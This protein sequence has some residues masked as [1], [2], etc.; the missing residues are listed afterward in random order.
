MGTFLHG[1]LRV[2]VH[3]A[4]DLL[5]CDTTFGFNLVSK[6]YSDPDCKISMICPDEHDL[7]L[8]KTTRKD[9]DLNPEWNETFTFYVC[10]SVDKLKFTLRDKDHTS[11][12]DYLG[13]IFIEGDAIAKTDENCEEHEPIEEQWFDLETQGALCVTVRFTPN[14]PEKNREVESYFPVMEGN[15]VTLYQDAETP[16]LPC[17]EGVTNADD[18]QYE[19]TNCW[20]DLF[21]AIQEAE[22]FIYITGWSVCVNTSLLRDDD[23]AIAESN[24]GELLKAKAEAGVSVIVIVWDE[25]TSN[26][27]IP[28]GFMGT[29]DEETNN[30][31][32]DTKVQCFKHPRHQGG[33]AMG[34]KGMIRQDFSQTCYSHHQ[35][36]VILDAPGGADDMR[37]IIA[38][39]GGLDITDGRYD[40]PEF[41]LWS[42]ISTRHAN[43][44]D[45]Y[46]NCTPG[47]TAESGPRQPWH[48]IHAKIEGPAAA[49]V[50]QNFVERI[51]QQSESEATSILS[52]VEFDSE[53]EASPAESDGA[54]WNVQLFR[55]ITSESAIFDLDSSSGLHMNK[56]LYCENSIFRAYVQNIRN[57]QN[58]VYVE[59]QYFLGSSFDWTDSKDAAANHTVP[60]EIAFK[61]RNKIAAGEPFAAYIVIPMFPEGD[62][63][64]A[65]LQ[66]ILYWQHRTMQMMYTIVADAIKE[67]GVEAKP[68]DYLMFFCLAKREGMN[69]IP[70]DIGPP[71]AGTKA[72]LVRMTLRHPIYVHCKMLIVDDDYIIV[73]SANINQ[74]SLGGNRDSEIAFG[75]WQPGYTTEEMDGE[76]RGAV[77]TFRTALWAAH[78]GG[79]YDEIRSPQT[80]ECIEKV[81]EISSEYWERYKDDD[82][83]HEDVKLLRYP[84]NIDDDGV[85]SALDE[86]F[87]CFPDTTAPILGAK[88][89]CMPPKLTT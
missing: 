84:V 83:E 70:E 74:R 40:T 53:S 30:F 28:G 54:L 11:V 43:C 22:R 2:T 36:T 21:Q 26:A 10:H 64:T 7:N 80:R 46:N 89:N 59:N 29:H 78:L 63:T 61:I 31:F 73:G 57:A 52:I 58:Y 42:T 17:F 19:P 3:Q 24:V 39:V 32:A 15:K 71:A 56:G 86:P 25:R 5:D 49:M 14:A 12:S 68:T 76:P 37:R 13:R 33:Q 16:M 75:A 45:F 38:F 23:D 9:N 41:H 67:H 69:D 20:K 1:S 34:I 18:S 8:G 77:H 87:N 62:P 27:F 79:M 88:S 4:R 85:V 81:Q 65:A 51:M 72:E 6:N 44:N 35:K 55:S 50:R 60:A 48:D 47:A 82:G 66:E